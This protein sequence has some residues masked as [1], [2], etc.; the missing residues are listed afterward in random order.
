MMYAASA[1]DSSDYWCGD[2][3]VKTLL[4]LASTPGS[5]CFG[6]R[7]YSG[8]AFA[9]PIASYSLSV[10]L[11]SL[12]ILAITYMMLGYLLQGKSKR[13]ADG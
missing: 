5:N 3:R 13:H 4:K 8:R 7:L 9:T 12:E 10:L 1:Q 2:D 11:K 6:N